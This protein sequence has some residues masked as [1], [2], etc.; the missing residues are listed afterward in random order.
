V[1]V[2]EN[3]LDAQGSPHIRVVEFAI[4]PPTN[5]YQQQ[6]A[7]VIALLAPLVRAAMGACARQGCPC[8]FPE[9]TAA[10]QS[11]CIFAFWA[12]LAGIASPVA[13]SIHVVTADTSAR[14]NPSPLPPPWRLL[15]KSHQNPS[16]RHP[17]PSP[18]QNGQSVRPRHCCT[19]ARTRARAN[20]RRPQISHEDEEIIVELLCK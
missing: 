6:Q 10:P 4:V 16:S 18:R 15:Q 9:R 2:R 13:C 5:T 14:H 11:H 12:R 20:N 19:P 3:R 1:K 17:R 8:L 7:D